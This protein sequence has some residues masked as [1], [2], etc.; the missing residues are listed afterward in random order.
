MVRVMTSRFTAS[1][2]PDRKVNSRNA[3]VLFARLPSAQT[4]LLAPCLMRRLVAKPRSQL[5]G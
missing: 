3:D 2:S 1:L 4:A 5:S